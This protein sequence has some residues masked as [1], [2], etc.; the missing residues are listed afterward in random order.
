M[1][2]SLV[3]TK[4]FEPLLSRLSAERFAG[5]SYVPRKIGC[6]IRNLTCRFTAYETVEPTLLNSRVRKKLKAKAR[7][8][9]APNC[10]QDR[11]SDS[12]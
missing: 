3:G 6:E 5:L 8:E 7:L 1:E 4:G 9:L 10:L 12:I 11:R 2:L